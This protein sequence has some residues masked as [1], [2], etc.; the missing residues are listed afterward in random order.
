MLN[1]LVG[2]VIGG[3]QLGVGLMGRIGFVMKAAVGKWATQALVKEEEQQ[4]YLD[5]FGS[6]AV[7]VAG[8]VA[9][10]QAVAFELTQVVAELIEGVS[11]GGEVKRGE[12][13]LMDLFGGPA[14]DFGSG[15]QEDFQQ[16][17]DACFMDLD[18]GV[19]NRSNDD[20]Q[21]EAL[22]QGEIDVDVEPLGLEV[23]EAVGD[24]KEPLLDRQQVIETLLQS[25]VGQVIGA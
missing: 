18:T 24:L 3:F 16:T 23:G 10:E 19:T 5:A 21:G 17:N 1:G 7:G 8:A 12:D 6:Q 14:T 15:M 13:S 11:V 25:E 9:L 20:G 22:E 2:F 4:G